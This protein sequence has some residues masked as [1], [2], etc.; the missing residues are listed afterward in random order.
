M[1]PPEFTDPHRA[2]ALADLRYLLSFPRLGAWGME[3]L[4][5][6]LAVLLPNEKL[7]D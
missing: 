1:P 3:A 6:T 2:L 4:K 7:H 5:D